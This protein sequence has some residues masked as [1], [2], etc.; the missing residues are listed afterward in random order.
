MINYIQLLC[1][2]LYIDCGIHSV[3][4]SSVDSNRH[5]LWILL[6]NNK[7]HGYLKI[8]YKYIFILFRYVLSFSAIL[9]KRWKVKFRLGLAKTQQC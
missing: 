2:S 7:K 6:L 1:T 8:Q 3:F 5:R 9:A 4:H